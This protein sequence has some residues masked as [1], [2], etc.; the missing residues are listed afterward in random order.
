M[1][2]ITR[3]AVNPTLSLVQ[4]QG[5]LLYDVY[6]TRHALGL[7]PMALRTAIRSFSIRVICFIRPYRH[8]FLGTF[9]QQYAL[10]HYRE[11]PTISTSPL[12]PDEINQHW[13]LLRRRRELSSFATVS[14]FCTQDPQ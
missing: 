7:T 3:F 9:I 10:S 5:T 14:H 13:D 1:I 4:I 2:P 11:L 8:L 12:S 6:Q